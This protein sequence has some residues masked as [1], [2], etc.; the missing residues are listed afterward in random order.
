MPFTSTLPVAPVKTAALVSWT[1]PLLLWRGLSWKSNPRKYFTHVQRSWIWEERLH[2][3]NSWLFTELA[4]TSTSQQQR[5]VLENSAVQ[6][7][8]VGA[9]CLVAKILSPVVCQPDSM[10]TSHPL[11]CSGPLV[12]AADLDACA[13]SSHAS[14]SLLAPFTICTIAN[15]SPDPGRECKGRPQEIV[16]L[17][18]LT[19]VFTSLL[20]KKQIACS[21]SIK[22]ELSGAPH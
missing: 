13:A 14:A 9:I 22:A 7:T 3:A 21:T 1:F 10:G 18:S 8:C 4:G 5:A 15:G 11:Q 19:F 2:C 16:N 17:A 6:H 20:N 12:P